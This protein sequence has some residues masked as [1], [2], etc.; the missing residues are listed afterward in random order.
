MDAFKR[1]VGLNYNIQATDSLTISR[2]TLNNFLQNYYNDN[3]PLIDKKGV[4]DDL[5]L[6]YFG[7][8]TEVYKPYGENLY[9]YDVNSLYPFAAL[10]PMPG[11][12]CVYRVYLNEQPDID[13]LFGFFY[14]NVDATSVDNDYI[15]LLPVRSSI[16]M[17][18]PLGKWSGGYFS[19]ILKFAKNHGYKTEVIKGYNHH[20]LYDVFTKYVTTLYETKVNAVNPV[21]RAISKSFLNNLLGRFGLNTAKPISG[22][23]NKKE[24]DIIQT[25]RVIHDIQEFSENTFFITFEAMPDK[26]TCERCNIDYISALED[27]TLKS[28]TSGVVIENDIDASIAISSAVNAYAA[29]Y[30]NKLKLDCL[31]AGINIYYSD[32]DSLATDKPLNENLVGKKNRSV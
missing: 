23:V 22:L 28:I 16:G 6:S 3:I 4:I 13:N 10:N 18:M 26:P 21:Q 7:G 31:K 1:S 17:S 5:R 8:I 27:T 15:G 14:V 11:C 2:L 20:K 12:E 24:F 9:C 30:I 19:E 25:T 32:T 29:I